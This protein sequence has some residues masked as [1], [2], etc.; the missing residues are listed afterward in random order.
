MLRSDG[1]IQFYVSEAYFKA[2]L[3]GWRRREPQGVE[4][5]H[6]RERRLAELQL[7]LSGKFEFATFVPNWK[8]IS[9]PF[10][11]ACTIGENVLAHSASLI[12]AELRDLTA[13]NGGAHLIFSD[14]TQCKPARRTW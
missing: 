12:I 6:V 7:G 2:S 14:R 10:E 11:P 5:E 8:T 4:F 3:P 13:T 9:D 1:S